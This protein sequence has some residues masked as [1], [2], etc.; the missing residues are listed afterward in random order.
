MI[1]IELPFSQFQGATGHPCEGITEVFPSE[2]PALSDPSQSLSRCA[3]A[4]EAYGT[5]SA[6]G[7]T[8]NTY[9][10]CC[11]SAFKM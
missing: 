7:L 3:G 1:L 6:A 4:A 10:Y 2:D 11:S 9:T 5:A 8:Y